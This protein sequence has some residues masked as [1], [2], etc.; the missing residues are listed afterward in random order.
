MRRHDFTVPAVILADK[1][2]PVRRG[3]LVVYKQYTSVSHATRQLRRRYNALVTRGRVV[4][5][6]AIGR[7]RM[8]FGIL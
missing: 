3:L 8:R 4:V 5:E 6:N 1:A 2:Y 7:M